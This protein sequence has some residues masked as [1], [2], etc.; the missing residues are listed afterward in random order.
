[1]VG[2]NYLTKITGRNKVYKEKDTAAPGMNQ[3]P[4]K[5]G[6]VFCQRVARVAW[7]FP[8]R[9]S[10]IAGWGQAFFLFPGRSSRLAR[11][12]APEGSG[13]SQ[14]FT[15]RFR[16]RH[17]EL[18]VLGH[19]NNVA[20]ITYMQEAAIEASA[21]AG[22][23]PD[24]YGRQGVGWVVRR[25]SVRYLMQV[26]YGE[27]I[28]VTTWVAH[29]RGVRCTREYLITRARDGARVA[30]ARAEW[31]YVDRATGKPAR[32]PAE[33]VAAFA[34]TGEVE[35]LGVRLARAT[36]TRDAHRYLS[37]RRVQFHELDPARHVS[38][39]AYLTWVGQAY[40]DAIRAAGHPLERTR[41]EGWM[42]LQAGH[43]IEYYTPARD[44]DPVEVVSWVCEMARVR[45]AWTH[46]VYQAETRQ[47]LARNYSLGV[48]VNL[49]GKPTAP[50]P[51]ALEDVLRGPT[52]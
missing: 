6:A 10:I 13:M 29:M 11:G 51:E 33:L 18:D 15:R 40:F 36:A 28:E 44:N 16:V 2:E 27:E 34:A 48:F 50:P 49:E 20:Y 35:D 41:R 26:T 17:A 37:R 43:D 12:R 3:L 14:P 39:A 21:R 4:R 42:V 22:Y 31:V 8:R 25:L 52:V 30:R 47:L 1:M 7:S 38:H 32:P 24:W 23:G 46:E 45:G 5:T 9:S 19:V